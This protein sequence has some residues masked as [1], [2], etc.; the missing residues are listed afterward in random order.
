M[1]VLQEKKT[2]LCGLF[3]YFYL[4]KLKTFI[5][6]ACFLCFSG[7]SATAQI[8]AGNSAEDLY[9]LSLRQEKL[10]HYDSAYYFAHLSYRKYRQENDSLNM[11]NIKY[12][13]A[14][15]NYKAHHYPGSERDCMEALE[16]IPGNAPEKL[17]ILL[18]N[19]L[20]L[21]ALEKNNL[22]EAEKYFTK[23]GS[24]ASKPG[25]KKFQRM[26]YN[27]MGLLEE[28]KMNYLRSVEYFDSILNLYGESIKP[29]VY[30]RTIANKGWEYY[31]N[32]HYTK[33]YP[34]LLKALK[35]F[36]SLSH[37]EGQALVHLRL[38][39]YFHDT[40]RT[41]QALRHATEAY[42]LNHK[43]HLFRDELKSLIL[44]S[45]LNPVHAEEYFDNYHRLNDSLIHVER[46][47]KEQTAKIRYETREK[48]MKIAEQKRKLT[49]SLYKMLA[50]ILLLVMSIA[51]AGILLYQKGILA[52]KNRQIQRQLSLITE[53]KKEVHH[54]TKNDLKRFKSLLS[55]T[56][57]D[58][59]PETYGKL[60]NQ[61]ESHILLHEMLY[62]SQKGDKVSVKEYFSS[63]CKLLSSGYE[64]QSDCQVDSDLE[65]GYD[66]LK[67]L[68]LFLNEAV[69]NI[70]KH[71]YDD[72]SHEVHI[73]VVMYEEKGN[74]HLEILDSGSGDI[75]FGNE[76]N[77][78]LNF[79]KS[80]VE[81][82]LK[83][84]IKP[85]NTAEKHGILINFPKQ[86]S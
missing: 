10:H 23:I 7:I 62:Q 49:S 80:M 43:L 24:L 2:V 72:P 3:Y 40:K 78:G 82:E 17:H 70:Y 57:R 56:R 14:A 83:G 61:L 54:K 18:Y 86:T 31:L 32:K 51:F 4:M 22:R 12:I 36:D 5:V 20:G 6:L 58:I 15:L 21:N 71:A 25:K 53:L 37:E 44:L 74:Y 84:S 35:V 39:Y 55:S 52:E 85:L 79:I 69:T 28:K 50:I 33:A 64:R 41:E 76:N 65:L 16:L 38:A 26:Y 11:A 67:N 81:K 77:F 29:H 8:Y 59:P 30:A 46:R 48:E 19:L 66:L 75:R 60:L 45:K 73:R 9:R 34:L 63:L 27:N 42:R 1:C 47:Y 13:M 68:A